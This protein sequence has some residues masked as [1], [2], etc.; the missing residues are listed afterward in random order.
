[1]S[2]CHWINEDGVKC[3]IPGCWGGV[4]WPGDKEYC[5][6]SILTD[7]AYD[8]IQIIVDELTALHNDEFIYELGQSLINHTINK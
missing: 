6:C 3:H 2:R 7:K 5:T 4:H 8:R 1:M